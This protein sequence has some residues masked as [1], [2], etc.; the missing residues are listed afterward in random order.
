MTSSGDLDLR[1]FGETL[2]VRLDDLWCLQVVTNDLV[3]ALSQ[4]VTMR[5]MRVTVPWRRDLSGEEN[6][7][8]VDDVLKNPEWSELSVKPLLGGLGDRHLALQVYKENR[9]VTRRTGG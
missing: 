5:T 9:W 1:R 6:R 3:S 7:R 8:V 4:D 2:E